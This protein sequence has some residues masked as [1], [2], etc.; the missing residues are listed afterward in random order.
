MSSLRIVIVDD[1]EISRRF[2]ERIVRNAG[3]TV[4]GAGT[5]GEDAVRLVES[6]KP[7]VI[8]MDVA[9]SVKTGDVAAREIAAL[10]HPPGI[11]FTTNLAQQFIT[12][13]CREIGARLVVK[14]FSPEYFLRKVESFDAKPE[15]R[16]R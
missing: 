8:T 14:P 5:T 16:L 9:M 13:L 11:V 15:G 3:H 1:V 7:D 6:L 4:V 12:D 2:I 10:P